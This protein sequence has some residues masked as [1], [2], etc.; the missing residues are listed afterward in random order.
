MKQL[1]EVEIYASRS[2]N[3]KQKWRWR[4]TSPNGRR[5]SKSSEGYYDYL[6]CVDMANH[7]N[8]GDVIFKYPTQKERTR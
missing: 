4:R 3:L 6:H 1:D 7:C 2:L 5:L 8:G